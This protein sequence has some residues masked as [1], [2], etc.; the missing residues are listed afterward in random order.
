[1]KFWNRPTID[2]WIADGRPVPPPHVVKQH[3]VRSYAMDYGLD[4]L[5]ETGTYLG[6]MVEAQ[7][8]YFKQ[9]YSIELSKD[10][11]ARAVKRFKKYDHIHLIQGDS[12]H[13]LSMIDLTG[14]ALFWLDGHYSGGI[15]AHG[16]KECPIL[17][18]L[19]HIEKSPFDN[20]I[21]IDDARLFTGGAY[22][23][24]DELETLLGRKVRVGADMIVC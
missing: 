18:E 20:V 3:I 22:P 2:K 21:L 13:A 11:H 12:S 10:L 8:K 6:T 5:V 24:I 9:I 23:T 7:R 15:T 14:P 19:E 17:E 16:D 4:T 1:M